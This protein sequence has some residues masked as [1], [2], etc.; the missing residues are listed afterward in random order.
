[1]ATPFVPPDFS[2][3]AELTFGA[4]RL[5]PL[6][7]EHNAADYAAWTSSIDHIRGTPGFPDGTWPRPMTPAE[8]L[9]DLERHANDFVLRQGFTYTVLE[10]SGDVVGC[11]YIYPSDDEHVDAAVLSWVRADR[12]E[13][14]RPLSDAVRAWLHR[15]WP[16]TRSTTP[17]ASPNKRAVCYAACG[18]RSWWARSIARAIWRRPNCRGIPRV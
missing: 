1:L 4:V 2:V 16:S 10:P 15:D 6:G 5:T 17:S 13:L 3:P 9:H 18:I 11:V 7:P 8:N 14:D 12:S